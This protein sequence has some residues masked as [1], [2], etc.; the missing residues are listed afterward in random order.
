VHSS[1]H[2]AF[3]SH[4]ARASAFKKSAVIVLS[5]SFGVYY[6]FSLSL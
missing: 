3:R 5:Q 4:L 6:P 2:S 1:I